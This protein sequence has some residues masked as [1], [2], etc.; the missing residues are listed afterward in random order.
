MA[1]MGSIT[2]PSRFGVVIEGLRRFLKQEG[3]YGECGANMSAPARAAAG[4]TR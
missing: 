2:T 1:P 3:D 4:D